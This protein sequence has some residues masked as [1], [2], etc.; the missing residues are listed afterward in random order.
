M[1]KVISFPHLGNYYIPIK[2]IDNADTKIYS[3]E[4]H[5]IIDKCNIEFSDIY[6]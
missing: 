3:I 6:M 5:S 2:T 4:P 1:N